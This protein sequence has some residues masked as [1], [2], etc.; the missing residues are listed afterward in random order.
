MK[1]KKYEPHS[2]LGTKVVPSAKDYDRDA[3]REE[4]ESQMASADEDGPNFLLNEEGVYEDVK[5]M[6][7][8]GFH[9]EMPEE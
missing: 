1:K 2:K 6:Y 3:N 7:E 8:R 4:I 9:I 5:T